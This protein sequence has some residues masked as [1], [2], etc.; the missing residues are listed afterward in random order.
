MHKQQASADANLKSRA[1]SLKHHHLA[2]K[3]LLGAFSF[4]S[5]LLLGVELPSQN[6]LDPAD[7]WPYE[8][9]PSTHRDPGSQMGCISCMHEVGLLSRQH[10]PDFV[11][12]PHDSQSYMLATAAS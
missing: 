1:A 2:P 12:F 8:Y 4:S 6:C 9:Q 5:A 10:V 11:A 7:T 3:C